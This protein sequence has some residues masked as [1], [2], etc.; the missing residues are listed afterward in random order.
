MSH[1][2][3]GERFFEDIRIMLGYKPSRLWKICL[4]F[5]TPT[6]ILVTSQ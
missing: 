6:V 5:I 1:V 4:Q 2:A 3:G